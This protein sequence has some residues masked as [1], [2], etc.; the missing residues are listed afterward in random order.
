MILSKERKEMI[1]ED[2]KWKCG[3][4]GREGDI[5]KERELQIR[6]EMALFRLDLE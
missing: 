4:C 5:E 1:E 3:L 2:E 6:K